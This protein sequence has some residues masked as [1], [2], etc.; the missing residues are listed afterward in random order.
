MS[1][2]IL[3]FLLLRFSDVDG[4]NVDKLLLHTCAKKCDMNSCCR[5][6]Q[7][8]IFSRQ[9]A[10]LA[11]PGLFRRVWAQ[12]L[13]LMRPFS[14]TLSSISEGLLINLSSLLSPAL[15][16]VRDP[17]GA[18]GLPF[19]PGLRNGSGRNGLFSHAGHQP[20]W[21]ERVHTEVGGPIL[22]TKPDQPVAS[23]ETTFLLLLVRSLRD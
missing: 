11:K 12:V 2:S 19:L 4:R 16:E 21:T 7:I 17:P 9:A 5:L 15:A 18:P 8:D 10:V 20:M 1:R 22:L 23:R 14:N 3:L 13:A 6:W